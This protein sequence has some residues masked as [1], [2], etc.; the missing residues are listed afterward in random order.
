MAHLASVCCSILAVGI[1]NRLC[2]NQ[3]DYSDFMGLHGHPRSAYAAMVAKAAIL[4]A[5]KVA[6]WRLSA[7][8]L[9]RSKWGVPAWRL[10]VGSRGTLT[11]LSSGLAISA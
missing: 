2:A 9:G 1:T 5:A 8:C 7:T 3:S 10:G 6:F 11:T 4:G